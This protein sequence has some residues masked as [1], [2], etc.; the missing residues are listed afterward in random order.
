MST[1][2]FELSAGKHVKRE[3][4]LRQGDIRA[5][6]EQALHEISPFADDKGITISLDMQPESGL[7]LMDAGQIEQVFVN[8][9]ENACKFTPRS[10]L[11]E[12]HGA[13]YFWERRCN[14]SKPD[15]GERRMRSSREPNAYRIDIRD[16]G[17]RIPQDQLSKIFEEYTSY[18]GGTDR[19]GGGLGLAICKMIVTAHSGRIWATNSDSGP[20]FSFVLPMRAEVPEVTPSEKASATPSQSV[21]LSL[22]STSSNGAAG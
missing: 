18:N 3:P 19:S 2:L 14:N 4:D 9:L 10:G 12:I 1:A 21:Q 7:L 11:I 16:S 8:L 13:S 5:C 6:L 20:K 22:I 15:V 17:G